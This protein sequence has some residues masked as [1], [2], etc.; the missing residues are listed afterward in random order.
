VGAGLFAGTILTMSLVRM[1]EIH[2]II[3]DKRISISL[4]L[5]RFFS[6]GLLSFG[7]LLAATCIFML[8]QNGKIIWQIPL[9]MS[10]FFAALKFL[11]RFGGT[12][13]QEEK[14]TAIFK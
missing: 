6:L 5:Q 2:K 12:H 11:K 1:I 3:R 8:V 7:V 14:F 4:K 13:F 10:L 9:V